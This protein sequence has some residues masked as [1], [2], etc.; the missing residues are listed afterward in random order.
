VSCSPGPRLPAEV[1]SDAATCPVAPGL[2]SLLSSALTLPR[3][4]QLWTSPPVDRWALALPRVPWLQALPPREESSDTA[5]CSSA[6][7]LASLLRWALTLLRVPWLRALPPRE[8]SSGAA[9]YPT[10]P[11]ELWTTEIK[12]GLAPSSMQLG[13]HVFKARSRVTKAPARCAD[14][15][16]QFGPADH[17]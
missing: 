6:P 1:G 15:P 11:S 13:L 16:L 8:E 12:K 10:V 17:S 9:T 3:V 5:T 4:P 7:D 2:A 14:M